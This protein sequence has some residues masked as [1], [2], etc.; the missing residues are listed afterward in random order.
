MTDENI[1]WVQRLQSF[2]YALTQLTVAVELQQ[3]RSLSNL[4][5][6]GFVKA[7]EFTHEQAWK[8]M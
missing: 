2:S 3:Q 8:V 6:Q 4:E 5:N 1:R 7:F